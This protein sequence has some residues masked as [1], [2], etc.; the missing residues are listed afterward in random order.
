MWAFLP[1]DL[2]L[3]KVIGNTRNPIWGKLRLN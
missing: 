2:V 1:G 3:R